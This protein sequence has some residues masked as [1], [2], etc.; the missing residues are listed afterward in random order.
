MG[1]FGA[2]KVCRVGWHQV[3]Y[4]SIG[5]NKHSGCPEHKQFVKSAWPASGD[6][7]SKTRVFIGEYPLACGCDMVKSRLRRWE[8]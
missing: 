2:R 4:D 7:H 5:C 6:H 1:R 8:R 3:K